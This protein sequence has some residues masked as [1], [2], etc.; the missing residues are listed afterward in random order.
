MVPGRKQIQQG[1]ARLELWIDR[2]SMLLTAMRMTFPNADTKLM[3]FENVVVNGP[4]DPKLFSV[5]P[6]STGSVQ[7]R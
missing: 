5:D 6:S 2:T 3:V 1:L 4:V 7:E